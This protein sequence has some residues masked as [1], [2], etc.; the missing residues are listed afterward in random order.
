[1]TDPFDHRL[2]LLDNLRT[3]SSEGASGPLGRR[4]VEKECLRIT[5]E[6]HLA[7]T[8][9]PAALGSTLAH[10]H[11]TTD[12]AE[13]LLELVTPPTMELDA[14]L[15][16]LRQ[17]H[18][19]AYG[20]LGSELLW[21]HS[22]PCAVDDQATIPIARFGTSN[23]GRF[24]TIYRIG[25]SHRYGAMMQLIAG[26]HYNFSFH[27]TL[28]DLEREADD[29]PEPLETHRSRR[30]FDVI[31][32]IQRNLWLLVYLFGASPA[33]PR[34]F[35]RQPN[36]PLNPWGDATWVMPFAT[37]LRMSD[38]GYQNST[39]T[40]LQVGVNSLDEYTEGLLAATRRREPSFASIGVQTDE[41]Y[42]QLSA[43]L[44]QIEDE[45]YA[46]VRPKRTPRPGQRSVGALREG[47][48]EYLELRAFDLDPFEPTGIGS[49]QARFIEL[50]L[51]WCWAHASPPFTDDD[52]RQARHNLR[53]VVLA[54]RQPGITLQVDLAEVPLPARGKALLDTMAPLASLLDSIENT[55]AFSEALAEQNAKVADPD[56]TPSARIL[57]AL[58]NDDLSFEQLGVRLA[59]GHHA[60]LTAVPLSPEEQHKYETQAL[61]SLAE[62]RRLEADNSETFEAFLARYFTE[63]TMV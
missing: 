3:L 9:H 48:V 33:L 21:P 14:C 24:K 53:Q 11:I 41:G 55:G 54:G 46:P 56:L 26:L 42:R 12:F 27:D 49:T 16:H 31:R 45:Y 63:P 4:G 40:R 17:L 28:W 35:V 1:M 60:S 34:A 7:A 43:N 38:I 22:M 5:P 13:P 20:C 8:P 39:Q 58:K 10:P 25:L 50:F 30:Y 32:N 57:A 51:L 52:A 2:R 47:G 6:G 29:A 19:F 59:Q 61:A 23:S 44:L 36:L 37:S 18:T 15:E 62:Q